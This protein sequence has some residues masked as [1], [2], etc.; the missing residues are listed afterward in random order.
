MTN[1][2]IQQIAIMAPPFLLAITFHEFSHGYVAWRLGDPTAQ[3]AGRLTMNPLKHLD[4]IGVLAFI[5]MKIGWAKPVP[6]NA[7]YF[8]N[9]VKDMMWVAIAGPASNL[10]L[11][12]IS[13]LVIKLLIMIEPVLPQVIIWPLINM[14]AISIWFNLVLAF[15]NLIPIPP[16]DG[17]RIITGLL[18]AEAALFFQKIEPFG[19]FLLLILFYLGIIPKLIMPMTNFAHSLI[20]G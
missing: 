13:A 12:L 14:V 11:A 18:P 1:N 2:I 20:A 15:F 8:K 17:S 6:V 9:P 5:I 7:A 16:L 10:L 3:N 4:P 19:F